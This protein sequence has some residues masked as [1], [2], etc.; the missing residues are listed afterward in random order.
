M[1]PCWAQKVCKGA[2][3][4]GA[5]SGF[6]FEAIHVN[7]KVRKCVHIHGGCMEAL[8]EFRYEN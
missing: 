3:G 6:P 2:L 5:R 7:P 1:I 4:E 8:G